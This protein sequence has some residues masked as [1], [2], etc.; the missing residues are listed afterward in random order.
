MGDTVLCVMPALPVLAFGVYCL[1]KNEGVFLKLIAVVAC[2]ACVAGLGNAGLFFM[3]GWRRGFPQ[4]QTGIILFF[5][6]LLCL[7]FSRQLSNM[8]QCFKRLG[9]TVKDAAANRQ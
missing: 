3:F 7:L 5:L 6:G 4:V 8:S 1:V 2:T 9:E